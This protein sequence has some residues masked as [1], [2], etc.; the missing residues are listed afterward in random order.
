MLLVVLFC[1]DG[2]FSIGVNCGMYWCVFDVTCL[3]ALL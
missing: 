2:G 1:K 3:V